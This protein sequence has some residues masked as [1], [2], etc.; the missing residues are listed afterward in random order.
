MTAAPP[1]ADLALVRALQA[2]DDSALD[3]LMARHRDP[4]FRFILRYVGNE[5]D[6][7]E[8]AQEAFVRAY[9]AIGRFKPRARFTTWLH[10]I[11][12]NLCR[13]HARS[14]RV[15][16]AARTDPLEPSGPGEYPLDPVSPAPSPRDQA[17]QREKLAAV[18]RGVAQ[19][20]HDLRAA[21][22]LSAME[23]RSHQECAEILQ[24]TAKAVEVRIYR[25]RQRLREWL[26]QAGF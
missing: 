7:V 23:Q 11:A 25:A 6:A 5:A 9:F 3:E 21:L 24:T 20:P 18:A 16:E 1:D 2:G 13:D 8:L 15:R 17:A 22:I 19:L 26:D 12:L 14:R 4:L 10:Q